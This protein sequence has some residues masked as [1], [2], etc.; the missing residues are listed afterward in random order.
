MLHPRP[1]ALSPPSFAA[2][3]TLLLS[4][5]ALTISGCKR[6]PDRAPNYPA[7]RPRPP[8]YGQPYRT[9]PSPRYPAPGTT[10]T[11]GPLVPPRQPVP[12][13]PAPPDPIN[14]LS[15]GF[16]RQRAQTVLAALVASLPSHQRSLVQSVPL[17]VDDEVGE[18][19]AFAACIDG[20]SL[21][22]VSDGLLEIQAQMARARATDEVFGTQKFNQ[23]TSLLAKYQQPKKPIV[24]PSGGFFVPS[25]DF[26][27]RK[28]QRQ[29]QL[30]DEQLAFVL[31]HELA[32]HYLGHTGCVGRTGRV[33]PQDLGRVLSNAV[34]VFNQPLE[35]ASDAAGIRNV[36]TTGA[37]R[38]GYK[39]TEGGA[40]LILKF[41]LALR[42]QSPA[43]AIL[44]GFQTT[45]PHPLIRS[46]V[47]RQTAA[48]WRASGGTPLRFPFPIPG[49]TG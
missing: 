27:Q 43:E 34:P 20:K 48:A 7:A 35:L 25:Q 16:F 5:A 42:K 2:I 1:H 38:P 17:V 10:A 19:N 18:V 8:Q 24:R 11:T 9:T 45:H 13:T 14:M 4:V 12:L 28:I 29:H 39:W 37:N 32:H 22:A 44:F 33:M 21:M 23:Y 26:D 36:L 30:F 6:S 31:G 49:I 40:M 47:V 3:L 15:I 41:F 46:P